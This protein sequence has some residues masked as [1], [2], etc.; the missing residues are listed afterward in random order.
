MPDWRTYAVGDVAEVFDGPHATPAK[1]DDGPWYLSIS[2]LVSGRLELA[3]SAHLSEDDFTRWTRRV[4]PS[5]GDVLFSYETRLGEAALMPEGV[6]AALGRRMGLLRP[7][8]ELVDPRFLLLAYR[9]PAFQQV[10]TERR[11]HGATVDRIPLV[12]LPR[13]P[14]EIPSFRTQE[15]VSAVLG[16]LEDKIAINDRIART[17][18]DL[19]Q[20]IFAS[21]VAASSI[22]LQDVCAVVMGQSPPGASYNEAGEGIP[23]YQGTRDFGFFFPGRRVWC[24][25]VTRR[26]AA[27]DVLVS[28]RAPVG[29]VN[30]AA[31]VCGIGRGLAALRAHASPHVL[32]HALTADP[33]VWAPF[34]GEGTVFSSIDKKRLHALKLKWPDR[35]SEARLDQELRA[36]DE[37]VAA[38]LLE[39]RSLAALRDFLLPELM[40][41]RLRVRDA[42]RA[43]EEAV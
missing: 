32:S 28:V 19:G 18:R 24:T 20:T 35:E 38:A 11:V 1:T 8:R 42:E 30:V 2:S 40:S 22:A 16:A 15:H 41:G 12:D 31:E 26:A 4:T 13:W 36:L 7:R 37:R 3:G 14:I 6:R 27:G 17:G 23:F 9:S 5:P 10:L 43:A 25:A 34:E 29:A 21:Q 33:A 39:N